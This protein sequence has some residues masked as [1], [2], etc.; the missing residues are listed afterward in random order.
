MGKGRVSK[1][2]GDDDS[3]R[4]APIMAVQTPGDA[5]AKAVKGDNIHTL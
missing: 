5:E 3:F 2:P 4:N 1:S